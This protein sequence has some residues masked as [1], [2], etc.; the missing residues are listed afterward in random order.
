MQGDESVYDAIGK[1]FHE[2][3]DVLRLLLARCMQD[4]EAN[5]KMRSAKGGMQTVGDL[6]ELV[7][8]GIQGLC[9]R[10]NIPAFKATRMFN[11][12]TVS[13]WLEEV[14]LKIL[15]FM[16]VTMG[17]GTEVLN[18]RT[19]IDAHFGK[20]YAED[21]AS[22]AL[23]LAQRFMKASKQKDYDLMTDIMQSLPVAG[24]KLE[25][26]HKQFS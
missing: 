11:F 22:A 19:A 26:Y 23:F 1:G 6:R 13:G 2:S 25:E 14:A 24:S 3:E 5:E 16:L 10:M 4:A 8:N 21:I 15:L 7:T 12:N 17:K 20:D 9:K 18:M